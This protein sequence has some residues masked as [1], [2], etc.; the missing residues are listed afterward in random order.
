MS[1]SYT[2]LDDL[3]DDILD[4]V[5]EVLQFEVAN[6]V[7]EVMQKHVD[8]DVYDTNIYDPSMYQRTGK[9]REEIDTTLIEQGTLMLSNT[10]EEDGRN[11]AQVVE[12][13]EGYTFRPRK[14][15]EWATTGW[16]PRPFTSETARDL[17]T[18]EQHTDAMSKG[19][20]AKGY[21]VKVGGT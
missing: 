6:E 21:D 5:D 18:N 15:H 8:I 10:R 1:K 20:I 19:L 4:D 9:L 17:E 13:G 14:G 2:N 11:I 16:Q 3:F 12:T 7:K